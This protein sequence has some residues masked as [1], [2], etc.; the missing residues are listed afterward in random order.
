MKL[1]SPVARK[2]KEQEEI[3]RKILRIQE[4]EELTKK[5]NAQLSRA[6]ADF[7]DVLARN[8]EKWAIEEEEH[9]NR[10]KDMTKEVEALENRKKDALIPI[11]MYK[12]EVDKVM[13]EAQEIIKK[14][15]EKEENADFLT[16]KLEEKLTELGDREQ[17]I[18]KEEQR[19][20]IAREGIKTQQESTREGI[21]RLSEEMVKFHEKQQFDEE[22]IADRKKE[23]AL[24]EISINAKLNKYT[25]DIEALKVWD[26][27]LHDERQTLDREYARE[28]SSFPI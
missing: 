14:A 10:I 20:E 15:K 17:N 16:E 12:K 27:Q 8:K 2:D 26:K 13:G 11:E 28:K 1:L 18:I 4:V 24:A 19:I 21:K 7:S 23:L 5:V 3:T 6:Q 22:N 25:R 9:F